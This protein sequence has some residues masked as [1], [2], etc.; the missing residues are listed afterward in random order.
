MRIII[1]KINSHWLAQFDDG[2]KSAGVG[3]N[4]GTAIEDLLANAPERQ[5]NIEDFK[6][7]FGNSGSDRIVMVLEG[8]E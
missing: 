1:K 3:S 2:S 4:A 8:S 6:P 7:D 5:L